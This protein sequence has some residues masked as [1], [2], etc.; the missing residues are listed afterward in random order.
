MRGLPP[1]E[2]IV[3]RQRWPRFRTDSVTFVNFAPELVI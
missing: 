3:G 2:T 1:K